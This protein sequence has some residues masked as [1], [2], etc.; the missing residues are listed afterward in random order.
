MDPGTTVS[1][2]SLRTKISLR[3][4][5]SQVALPFYGM[6]PELP[7]ASRVL[8]SDDLIARF[9][10]SSAFQRFCGPKKPKED[11]ASFLTNICGCGTANIS[12]RQDSSSS[13]KHLIDK[14]PVMGK[15]ITG[16]SSSAMIGFKLSAGP[17]PESYRLFETL[18]GDAALING[19]DQPSTSASAKNVAENTGT[20]E[21]KHRKRLKR[22]LDD[23]DSPESAEKKPKK[24]RSGDEKEKKQKKKKK[25]KKKKKNDNEDEKRTKEVREM[26]FY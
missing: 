23:F 3:G 25:D 7:P 10:L 13:L 6:K 4:G 20:A 26:P 2:G 5:Y 21:T 17:V 19:T 9:D 12:N 15:E 24:H 22:T 16:L 11:L 18:P 14:P 8:G 1:S